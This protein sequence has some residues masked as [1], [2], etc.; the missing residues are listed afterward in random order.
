MYFA[1]QGMQPEGRTNSGVLLQPIVN[2]GEAVPGSPLH[3]HNNAHWVL[4]YENAGTCA[5]TSS[6]TSSK[7]PFEATM[8]SAGSPSTR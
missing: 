3:E 1:G 2:L 6:A 4:L 7:A 5:E 8:G